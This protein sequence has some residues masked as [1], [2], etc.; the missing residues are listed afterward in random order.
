M[1]NLAVL[2]F[3]INCVESHKPSKII[4]SLGDS[5]H[6]TGELTT[7]S[8]AF[9]DHVTCSVLEFLALINVF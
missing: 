9:R 2:Y 3:G 6:D 5:T 4:S 7:G 1:L 8:S